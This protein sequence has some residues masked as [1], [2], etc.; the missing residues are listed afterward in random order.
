MVLKLNLQVYLDAEIYR[1]YKIKYNF[2]FI[3]SIYLSIN[4]VEPVH[5]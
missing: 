4:T 5:I 1:T 2:T 3:A